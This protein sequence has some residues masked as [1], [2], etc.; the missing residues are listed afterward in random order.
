MI[1]PA[2]RLLILLSLTFASHNAVGA[3]EPT[4]S[5][6]VASV[7]ITPATPIRLSGYLARKTESTNVAQRLYAKALCIGTNGDGPAILLTVDSIGV[8]EHIREELVRRL[9]RKG[10]RPER[11]A[12][13]STHSHT[14]P[15]LAGNLPTLFGEPIPPEHQSRIDRYTREL[16]DAL[17]KVSLDA[18]KNRRA[19]R[20]DWGIGKATF[21]A[22]RRT[23]GGPV[24]H[25]LPVLAV[26]D[27]DGNVRAILASYACHCT[28]LGA[29]FNEICGDWAGYA[30]EFLER[31]YPGATALLAI[32]CGADANPHPRPGLDFSKQH[33]EEI[34]RGVREVLGRTPAPLRAPLE[35][36]AKRI[37]LPFERVPSRAEWEQKADTAGPPGYYAR[38]NLAKLDRGEI[39]PATLPYLVQ[40]WNFGSE[41]A[42][43]FLP[44]EVV[45][46]Y[47]LR[48]KREFDSTRI[49]VNAYANDVPCYIPSE[50][51]LKE[52]GYEAESAMVYYDRPGRFATGVEA[53]IIDA[54]HALVPAAFRVEKGRLESPPPKSPEE[55]RGAM[56]TK[57]GF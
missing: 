14:A 21:A 33:G 39:L 48:L 53:L 12:V 16:I 57:A 19:A 38:H 31:D 34:A 49:W 17:E 3:P 50:R 11:V 9:S 1:K 13:C 46:D 8:P 32:G 35:C 28:T 40:T 47:S 25:D 10:I 4:F 55:S 42:M 41:L 6:G 37:E 52:G 18:L 45:V 54:V 27:A 15:C 51:I 24:D 30:Q 26:R 56:R 23:K 2:C 43:V 5:V 22:N 36:R 7:D 29:E 44:G 20:L